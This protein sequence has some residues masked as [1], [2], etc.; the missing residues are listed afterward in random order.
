MSRLL[1]IET[2]AES[3]SAALEID[4]EVRERFEHAP[5][6][7]AELLLPMVSSLLADA[8]IRASGLD[9]IAYGRGPG[10]FTSLRI[11]IGVVQGH[12]DQPCRQLLHLR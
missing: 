10:S 9:A 2:S 11:G 12:R 6:K 3:C 5:M 8:G 7:H 1:A 4:G